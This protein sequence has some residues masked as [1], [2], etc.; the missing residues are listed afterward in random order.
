MPAR[1]GSGRT[2]VGGRALGLS[3]LAGLALL[4]PLS[5][6]AQSVFVRGGT[7]VDP[8]TGEVVEAN[9]L[10]VDGR[11]AG[12]PAAAPAGFAGATVEAA[13]KW[14]IPGLHDLH[15]HS[16]GHIAPTG[17]VEMMGTPRTSQLMLYTGVTGFLDLFAPEDLIFGLRDGQR[18]GR[19]SPGAD[20]FAAGPCMTASRG[21]CT[22]YGVPTRVIDSP[23]DA[24]AQIDE[25]APKRPDVVKIVF[26]RDGQMP[27]ID[28]DTLQA[29]IAAAD[30]HGLK[31]VIHVGTNDWD[32]AREA[33]LAGADAVTHTPEGSVVPD[34]VVAILL[35]EGTT[36]IPTLAVHGDIAWWFADPSRLR[37][38]LIEAVTSKE[39]RAAFE[40]EP[41][42][43]LVRWVR[44]AV[45]L[46]ENR[47]TSVRKLSEAGVRIVTGTDAGNP[48]TFLGYSIH[49]ELLLL[50][51]AGLTPWQAL[52]A[53]TTEAGAFMGRAWGM[54]VGDEGSVVLLDASPI[55]DIRNTEKIHAVIHHGVPVDRQSLQ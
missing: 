36:V 49:R 51:E 6:S 30:R 1:D 3:V 27:T 21:H 13:G 23:E 25:L 29:A 54:A 28:V 16:F 2:S 47:D 43:G 5:A 42:G 33:A 45:E 31:T 50:V 37:N 22:E 48:G 38:P 15:T 41:Q 14:V 44:A 53:A 24:R 20:I 9:L 40:G 4:V 17:A 8:A 52:A 35:A 39:L 55:D 26:D 32:D 7:L 18:E 19:S 46:R 34:E 11:I 12:R 10:I